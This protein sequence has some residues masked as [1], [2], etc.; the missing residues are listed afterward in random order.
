MS[1]LSDLRRR[2]A[3]AA[4]RG[5]PR[6]GLLVGAIISVVAAAAFVSFPPALRLDLQVFDLACKNRPPIRESP[7]ILL[8]DMD[9]I[10]FRELGYPMPRRYYAAVITALDRLG[11]RQIVMDVEF[12]TRMFRLGEFDEETGEYRLTDEDRLLSRAIGSSGK[13]TLAYHVER[14]DPLSAEARAAFPKSKEVFAKDIA[15]GAEKV[16]R[17][18]GFARERL[19]NEMEALRHQAVQ[20]L[21]AEAMG[22]RPGLTFDDLRKALVPDYTPQKH[23]SFLPLL[24]YHYWM[25]LAVKGIGEKAVSVRVEGMPPLPL[26]AHSML[27]PL[28]PFLSGARGVGFANAEADEDGVIRRPWLVGSFEGRPYLYMGFEGALRQID[29]PV[30]VVIRP[31]EVEVRI[32]GGAPRRHAVLPIDGEGRMLL[33]W[34][35]NA[36]RKRRQDLGA[37]QWY[38]RHVTFFRMVT[39]HENRTRDLDANV[40]SIIEDQRASQPHHKEYL[41]LSGRLSKPAELAFEEARAVESRM[42]EIRRK[43]LADLETDTRAIEAE[44]PKLEGKQRLQDRLRQQLDKLR[45]WREG[46]RSAY[47]EEEKLRKLVEGK[48]CFVGSASTAGGDL[49]SSPLGPATPGV[50]AQANVA[51]M[52]L[53]GQVIRR[54]PP[55]VNFA[56]LLA[57]GLLVTLAVTYRNAAWSTAATAGVVAVSAGA[58]WMLFTGPSVLVS[59]AGPLTEA[60]FNFAAVMTFKEVVTRRSKRKL[61]RELEKNTSPELVGILIEHPELLARPRKMEG[62]FFF[63]DIKSFTSISEKMAPE[64]LVPFINRYLDKMTGALKRRQAFLDKYIGDGI[65]ALFGIPVPSEDHARNA[66]RAALESQEILRGLNLELAREGRPEIHSRIGIHSG[67]AIAG[68]VGAADRSDYTVLGDAV[69]LASRLEGANKEYGTAIMISGATRDR[70]GDEFELRELD[71]IRVVGKENAVRIFELVAPAG[72]AGPFPPGFLEAYRGALA[73]YGERRWKEAMDGFAHAL[74][75]KPG[76]TPSEIYAER[77][78]VFL[79]SPP[80]DGWDGVFDLKS[81]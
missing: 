4:E 45:Q 68:Y 48:I 6:L 71:R 39:F 21:V 43:I 27:P 13:V 17:E 5:D 40:R 69:N 42:D 8:V 34:A 3:R 30:E 22:K 15:A 12:K 62:T 80:A 66:C 14:G 58:Y 32:L 16:A 49:H 67:E 25:F 33:N 29:E 37:D 23:R 36:D 53:T 50:D 78:R 2:L 79:Q 31:S 20:A 65:M 35:G 18:T 51:N 60:V 64:V 1:L 7:D 38:F 63:S 54:V 57:A 72:A 46:I 81:K 61:Q 24:Q 28:H 52:T 75:L 19:E 74:E 44:L 41:D 76:D 70:V 77:A 73:S 47:D 26:T 55:W 10:T 9:D 59:G 56:G 11:A